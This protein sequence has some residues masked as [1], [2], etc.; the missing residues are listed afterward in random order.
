MP[1]PVTWISP[2]FSIRWTPFPCRE[3]RAQFLAGRELVPDSFVYTDGKFEDLLK[4]SGLTHPSRGAGGKKAKSPSV[5]RPLRQEAKKPS[6]TARWTQLLQLADDRVSLR[7]PREWDRAGQK[8]Q[9]SW[10]HRPNLKIA[11]NGHFS[12]LLRGILGPRPGSR[13]T[14]LSLLGRVCCGLGMEEQQYQ[15]F[16]VGVPYTA[17][18]NA[19][20]QFF[21]Q[22]S[23]IK[24]NWPP[25]STGLPTIQ[26]TLREA[27]RGCIERKKSGSKQR[28][29]LESWRRFLKL[30]TADASLCLLLGPP[31]ISFY[32]GISSKFFNSVGNWLLICLFGGMRQ[33]GGA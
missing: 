2:S 30:R 4:T 8:G 6:F 29:S 17:A 27:P 22:G 3:Q 16:G 11:N 12:T 28:R 5:G 15:A 19:P 13:K 21:Q 1:S 31:T 10:S 33:K 7:A 18:E 26:D 25:I 14:D 9:R 32:S 23:Q 20:D 24:L